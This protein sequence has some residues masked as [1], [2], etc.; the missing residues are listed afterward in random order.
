MAKPTFEPGDKVPDSGIYQ[1]VQTGDKVTVN[2]GDP[3][4]PTPKP[5]QTYKPVVLT[6]PTHKPG[7]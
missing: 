7:R 3:F 4:P 1:N 2:Q 5:G 6:D